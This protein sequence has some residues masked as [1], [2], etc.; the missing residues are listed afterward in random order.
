[1]RGFLQK[2]ASVFAGSAT[3]PA[4]VPPVEAP[5]A[6]AAERLA[7][8]LGP[9]LSELDA[10]QAQAQQIQISFQV[11]DRR[12]IPDELHQITI[13]TDQLIYGCVGMERY[14][15]VS[16]HGLPRN[17]TISQAMLA[18]AQRPEHMK[19]RYETLEVETSK[20]PKSGKELREVVLKA[21]VEA[22]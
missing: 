11:H 8:P 7:S 4:E 14:G 20:S 1:M 18:L 10:V 13:R 6:P 2:I 12:D 17:A 5:A 9:A 15:F 16:L 3:P 21:L 19:L 22:F